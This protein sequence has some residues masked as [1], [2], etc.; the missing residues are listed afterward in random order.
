MG[1]EMLL[2]IE[3]AAAASGFGKK[4]LRAMV[5]DG[6]LPAVRREGC[7]HVAAADLLSLGG[8]RPAG[9]VGRAARPTLPP[10]SAADP[11]PE[12]VV[13]PAAWSSASEGATPRP[14]RRHDREAVRGRA[15]DRTVVAADAGEG[16][17][18]GAGGT[19]GADDHHPAA[20]IVP[21]VAVPRTEAPR[22]ELLAVLEMLAKRDAQIATLQDE[23]VR[24]YAQIGLL[25]GVLA[26]REGR[27]RP[28]RALGVEKPRQDDVA[29]TTIV[30]RPGERQARK[31]ELPSAAQPVNDAAVIARHRREA[32]ELAAQ[33]PDL[34]A[35]GR[36]A[37]GRRPEGAILGAATMPVAVRRRL[38]HSVR[39]L[40]GL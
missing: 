36:L 3:Q 2:T 7:W 35:Y 11:H 28:L 9:V 23:R 14:A 21:G 5:R 25:Q 10:P 38:M 39:R 16:A 6:S 37:A 8:A 24:L 19:A 20:D 31:Q 13:I 4:A 22:A 32:T 40:L 30:A 1:Q 17:R 33:P 18:E 27:M 12:A 15:S 29:A 34:A 26:E